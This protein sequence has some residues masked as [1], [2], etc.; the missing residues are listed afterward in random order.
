MRR[1]WAVTIGFILFV[2]G[3]LSLILKLCGM[4]FIFM[5]VFQN[6]LGSYSS[7][8]YLIM[9]LG[10]LMVVAIALDRTKLPPTEEN[11]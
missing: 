8:A 11:V 6:V 1:T 10:G 2:L 5:R 4:Q 3:L 7:L 9:C